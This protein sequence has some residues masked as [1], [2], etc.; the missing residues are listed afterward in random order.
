MCAFGRGTD[1]L[2]TRVLAG[3]A[4][5]AEVTRF[6]PVRCRA[7]EAA[8]L[9]GVP[10]LADELT[11]VVSDACADA[12]IDVAGR[13]SCPLLLALHSDS[14]A[15]RDAA[16]AQAVG[17][18]A[19]EVTH[20]TGLAGPP[21]VYTTACVAASTA[22]ADAAAMVTTGRAERVVVAAGYLVD[23]DS[24]RL[25]DAGRALAVDGLVRPFS[26]GRCGMLLG[27]GVAAVVVESAA[28][29]HERGV[30][31][32]ATLAGWGRAGDAY[33]VCQPRPD[34]AG[35]AR[36]IGAALHRAGISPAD[37][38][39]V[40]ASGSG[41]PA[42]DV[43]EAAGLHHAFGPA[44]PHIPVSSTKSTHGHALEASA[45]L[46]L[47]ATVLALRAG[48]LPVNAGFLAPDEECE[49]DLVLAGPREHQARYALSVNSA[50]G[51]ANTA[52]LV[53]AP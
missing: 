9:P 2:L 38:G 16:A 40:N 32:L 28:S 44:M 49:L 21:A 29:A 45:L 31:V 26:K 24:F 17:A 53:G 50:F 39:Y 15:A 22:V 5:F 7:S 20:R 48:Q 8:E 14:V 18:V 47:V 34:G 19:T 33:H 41:T 6:E 23:A 43:A 36:A 52:L 46:E 11:A 30:R 37:V 1:V 10:V 13:A 35:L 42:A 27:D 12:E 4:A 3:E 25:F 51:G